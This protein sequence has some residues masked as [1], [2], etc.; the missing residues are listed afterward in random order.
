MLRPGFGKKNSILILNKNDDN[1]R[2]ATFDLEVDLFVWN[3]MTLE[4]IGQ[5]L[6]KVV[7]LTPKKRVLLVQPLLDSEVVFGVFDSKYE[8]LC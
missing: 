3:M 1:F 2:S 6:K 8:F 5:G 4:N 7:I